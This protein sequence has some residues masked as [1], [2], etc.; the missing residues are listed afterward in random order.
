VGERAADLGGQGDGRVDADAV[1][2]E[3]GPLVP[4][5]VPDDARG[6]VIG[7][8]DVIGAERGGQLERLRFRV[9]RDHRGR[10]GRLQDLDGHMPQASGSDH[11]RRR[12]PV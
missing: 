3:I 10:A 2:S 9:D 7:C 1:E 5:D 6:G 8:D 11:H 12:A 4:R